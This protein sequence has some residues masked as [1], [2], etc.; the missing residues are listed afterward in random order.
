MYE[1]RYKGEVVAVKELKFLEAS[2][3]QM[4]D[5]SREMCVLASVSHPNIVNFVG[6]SVDPTHLAI[7]LEFM[8][9]GDVR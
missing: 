6:A 4:A 8:G 2:P 5:F 9:Q 3:E 7:V 1:A